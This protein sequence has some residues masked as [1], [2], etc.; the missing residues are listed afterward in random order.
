M[1]SP[2]RTVHSTPSMPRTWV[3]R[4][5]IDSTVP[6]AYSRSTQSPT[7]TMSSKSITMPATTSLMIVC[8]PMPAAR[9][10]TPRLAMTGA[11]FTPISER[12]I[13][14]AIAQIT[15]R[16][17]FRAT[18]ERVSARCSRRAWAAFCERG[19]RLMTV[20]AAFEIREPDCTIVVKKRRS[21][22]P[23]T[24][25]RTVAATRITTIFTPLVASHWS[26]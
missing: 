25:L 18:F 15:A 7:A 10:T 19:S 8:A 26:S 13:M 4:R 2:L 20:L 11:M 17:T 6:S 12:I 5:L 21:S 1:I 23:A 24:R 9:P 14:N 22:Q 3:A 16:A